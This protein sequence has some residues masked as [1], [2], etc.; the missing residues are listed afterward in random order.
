MLLNAKEPYVAVTAA[1]TNREYAIANRDIFKIDLWLESGETSEH[2]LNN[3]FRLALK[4]LTGGTASDLLYGLSRK[5]VGLA[6][7]AFERMDAP[8]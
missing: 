8:L 1:T 6:R 4:I 5:Q 3:N 2:H 7:P